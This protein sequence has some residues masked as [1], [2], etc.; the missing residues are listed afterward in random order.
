MDKEENCRPVI[1]LTGASGSIGQYLMTELQNNYDII[2][3]S[4]NRDQHI[5]SEHVTWRACD[6]FSY[7]DA[8]KALRGADYAIY[9]IHSLLP[10]AKLT[11]G[12]FE[13][14]DAILAA[15]FARAAQRN[16]VKKIVYISRMIPPEV[17]NKD[18][19]QHLRSKLEVK[20]ILGSYDVPVTTFRIGQF[21]GPFSS[22]FPIKGLAK[23]SMKSD[24]RS[25][26]RICLPEGKN[27]QWVLHYYIEWLSR[28]TKPFIQI[29]RREDQIVRILLRATKTP[30]LELTYDK[31][32]S[33]PTHALY[34]ISGGILV[35]RR[36]IHNGR[37]EF[38]QLPN[39]R[40]CIV[41]IHDYLPSLP[42][43][44][45][46]YTQATLHLW[47]MKAFDLHLKELSENNK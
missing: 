39:S 7:D 10:S 45:Y 23:K 27:A 5:S 17:E 9:L 19:S 2:A 34:Q 4:R 32:K 14:M 18:V 8:E 21:V 29:K 33:S 1:A 6:F 38:L 28:I 25:I 3:I 41:A 46:K 35:N 47:V 20:R 24:V 37:L 30:L 43:F 26:Q 31:T 44:I 22:P 40:E 13:D 42:W 11:Q 15:H 36:E 16:R 12:S